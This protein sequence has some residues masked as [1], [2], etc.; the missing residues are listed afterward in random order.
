MI[1]SKNWRDYVFKD[2]KLIGEFEL[3]YKNSEDIPWNQDND[4]ERLDCK[5]GLNI[6]ER[7]APYKSI[8]EVGCG[9]GYFANEISRFS[10][11]DGIVKRVDISPTA[12]YKAKNLFPPYRVCY[13]RYY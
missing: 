2:G 6:L 8:L 7:Y 5:I 13:I 3:M 12:V 1:N 10:M 11:K 4:S 9:L